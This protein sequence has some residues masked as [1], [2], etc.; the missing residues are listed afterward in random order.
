MVSDFIY[1][2]EDFTKQISIEN[3]M[4]TTETNQE[5]RKLF[6]QLRQQFLKLL[7][8]C[9]KIVV[10]LNLKKKKL[11]LLTEIQIYVTLRKKK[12]MNGRT[13]S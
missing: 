1:R 13:K 10:I 3:I 11:F 7:K 9:H 8:L 5:L 12:G 6:T 2:L 4:I